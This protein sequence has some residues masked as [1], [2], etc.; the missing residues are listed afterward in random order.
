M[1]YLLKIDMLMAVL[2]FGAAG[3]AIAGLFIVEEAK[4]LVAARH[5][6]Y[7]RLWALADQ[8][9]FFANPLAISRSVSRANHKSSF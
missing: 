1:W 3:I 6:I 5:R 7:Q 4:A 2:V 9:R 8:P